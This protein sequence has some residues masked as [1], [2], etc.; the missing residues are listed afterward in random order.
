MELNKNSYLK[1]IV[2]IMLP[3]LYSIDNEVNT[4]ITIILVI[5]L[6]YAT[7]S[8]AISLG[9]VYLFWAFMFYI[10]PLSESERI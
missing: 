3:V 9:I 1:T 2:K 10:D 5:A 7:S 4:I 8:V 6:I